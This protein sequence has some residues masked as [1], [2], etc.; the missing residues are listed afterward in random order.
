MRVPS[1]TYRVQLTPDFGFRALKRVIPYLSELGITDL[2][3]SP[4][5]RARKGSTHGYDVVD[6][7]ALNPE[8]GT[9]KEFD[10][11]FEELDKHEMGWIQDIVPNHMAFHQANHMLADVLENGPLSRFFRFF[12]VDW[13]HAYGAV[14]GRVLAPFLGTF[15]R[16]ALENGNIRLSYES[17]GF[18]IRYYDTSFP[19]NL[20]SYPMVLKYRLDHLKAKLGVDD[21]DYARLFG[22]VHV[23]QALPEEG[24]VEERTAQARFIKGVLWEL[25]KRNPTIREFVLESVAAHNGTKG[26][27]ESYDL[28]DRLLARQFFRLS[29]WKV[30]TEE[31][32]YR[33]FFTI[34]ELISLRLEEPEVLETTHALILK[35]VGEGKF[36]GIRVDHIDGL[37]D[38]STYLEE[39]R[40][41]IG[42]L[43]L[44][45]EKIIGAR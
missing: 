12:D 9:R 22:I 35:L 11:L 18:R 40:K 39:I 15:Y 2:Y 10:L 34:N 30:A 25:Y 28:M 16:E 43:Y 36:T 14:K 33:R 42:D 27:S 41:R 37:Y 38:P 32:N 8:L 31:I 29:F 21:P 3:A 19:L 13:E 1:A 23:L 20:R 5:F 26:R 6:P 17:E 4:V 24:D 44:V 7:C 45:V